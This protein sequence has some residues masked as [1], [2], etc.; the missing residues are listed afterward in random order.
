MK[1]FNPLEECEDFVCI[2]HNDKATAIVILSE[3]IDCVVPKKYQSGIAITLE[4]PEYSP[5]YIWRYKPTLDIINK[6]KVGRDGS[7]TGC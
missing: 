6:W 4:N 3:Q 1:E 7:A 5:H 2:R